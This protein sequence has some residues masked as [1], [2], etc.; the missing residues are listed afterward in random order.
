MKQ[1]VR[2]GLPRDVRTG[3]AHPQRKMR[4]VP[5]VAI[6][7]VEVEVMY[8]LHESWLNTGML[9]QE[10]VKESGAALLRS[11]NEKVRQRP[12]WRCGQSPS[13]PGSIG[14][15]VASFHNLR[16]LSQVQPYCK[17]KKLQA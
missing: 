10:L 12:H 7:E 11:D 16:F 2:A 5:T 4:T 15:L 1:V 14:L 6:A 17:P 13:M 3:V 9:H 8:F